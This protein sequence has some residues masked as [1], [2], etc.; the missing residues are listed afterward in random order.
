MCGADH[1]LPFLAVGALLLGPCALA[2]EGARSPEDRARAA[3]AASRARS[4]DSDALQSNYVTPGLAGQSLTTV[5]N[6]TRFTPSLSCQKTATL[7]ELMVQPGS[8]GDLTQVRISHDR[9]FDGAFDSQTLL[10]ILVSGV[11]ANGVIACMPG[12]WEG[13]RS[14]RWNVDASLN[15]GLAQ[16]DMTQLSGCYCLNNSCGS[17]L[18]WGNMTGLLKDLG[19]G[20]IG[21]LTS[22]DPRIG[23]A[24][25]QVGGP[26]IRYTGAQTTACSANPTIDQTR[27]RASPTALA[28]DAQS[29]AASSSIFQA[30]KASPAGTGKAEQ[31]SACTV[32][33][34]I[35]ISQPDTEA[36]IKRSAGGYATVQSGP[37][38]LAF[39]IGSPTDD[40]LKGGAC[41]IFDFRMTLDV[42][43]ADRLRAV[44]IASYFAD[45]WA[46]IRVDGTLVASGPTAWTGM[47]P[48]P[49]KCE[50]RS[51]FHAAPELDISSAMTKGTHEIWMRVAVANEGE[52]Q[53]RIVADLDLGCRATER[54]V[55][56]CAG[57][58]GQ[59]QCRLRDETVDDVVTFRIGAGT[60]LAPLPQTRTLGT[61]ACQVQ[62]TRDFFRRDRRYACAVDTASLPP[63]DLTRGAYIID[64]STE[65]LLADRARSAKGSYQE[66][67][68][69]F[70][71][72]DRGA[73]AACEPICKTRK[74]RVNSDVAPEGVV[75]SLQNDPQGW[76]VFYH[77]CTADSL[78][79]AGDGEE[80]V[81]ACGCLDDFPEAVAMMQTVRLA[82]ADLVCTASRR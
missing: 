35:T 9:D 41:S 59:Q 69:P 70:M 32:M 15:I 53:A 27:Y 19:G 66:S 74:P 30:V 42:G 14:Y 46:Q 82:G 48:P 76:D 73:V 23:V 10:P 68:R 60:G 29:V 54:I 16:T 61:P 72:P 39:L 33:R 63:P 45:D 51:S 49:G 6:K 56:L 36:I 28:S 58:A 80:L 34:D 20:V 21:A 37:A 78:C 11:C 26:V 43:E 64:R 17:N 31:I 5:D 7:L 57:I 50:K 1:L 2:Q 55:D 81:S 13:C 71:M 44:R 77:S 62:I 12:T 3:A 8:T 75:G 4:S 52:A 38:Q 47:G 65:T 22:A 25:A 67:R 40:S 18:A 79:P 24:Q